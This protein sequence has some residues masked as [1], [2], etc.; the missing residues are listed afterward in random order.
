[1]KFLVIRKNAVKY[2][3]FLLA[4]S[5]LLSL[6]LFGMPSATVYFGQV[7]RLVPIYGVETEEKKVAI[8]FDS[9]WGADKTLGIL[10]LLKKI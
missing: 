1:M 2:V 7:P 9:A 4:V 6:N 10:D 8:T 3:A 5:V